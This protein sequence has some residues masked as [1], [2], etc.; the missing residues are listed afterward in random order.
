MRNSLKIIFNP[1]TTHISYFFK[2]EYGKW[3]ELSSSSPLSRQEYTNAILKEKI[4]DILKKADEI[5][6]R[7]NTGLDLVF[8]G[9]AYDYEYLLQAIRLYYSK[10]DI[11]CCLHET[12]I[13]VVGKRG[14][15]KTCLIKAIAR[16]QNLTYTEEK[17][18]D[19]ILYSDNI[20][21]IKWYEIK[22]MDSKP[23]ETEKTFSI[24]QELAKNNLSTLVYCVSG[25]SNR[26][27]GAEKSFLT[28]V[29]EEMPKLTI[30]I[31]LTKC[32]NKDNIRKF[33]DEISKILNQITVIPTL[34]EEYE[35]EIDDSKTGENCF[36]IKPDGIDKL[37]KYVLERREE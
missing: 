19:Y 11:T 28:R 1:N 33:S 29:A 6:N 18:K 5:Y 13:A 21:N 17:T 14:I 31:V 36:I 16:F 23:K 22:G 4:I 26:L 24:L 8:E 3:M 27:E 25:T 15:G 10:R 2:N 35:I 12:Q 37:I 32:I 20:N 34:A 9:R 7:K 30:C